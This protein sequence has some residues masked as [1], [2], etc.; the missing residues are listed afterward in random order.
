MLP[1]QQLQKTHAKLAENEALTELGQ[2][3]TVS[4][5]VEMVFLSFLNRAAQTS[6]GPPAPGTDIRVAHLRDPQNR[7]F[8][9]F[10]QSERSGT[11]FLL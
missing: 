6:R 8:G 4:Q 7:L 1:S 2:S 5:N 11:L 10:R 9:R 3:Q